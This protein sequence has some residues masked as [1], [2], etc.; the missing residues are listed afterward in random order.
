MVGAGLDAQLAGVH[1]GSSQVGHYWGTQ[2][3]KAL[4][5]KENACVRKGV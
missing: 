2:S 1:P 5:E 3:Y 4:K